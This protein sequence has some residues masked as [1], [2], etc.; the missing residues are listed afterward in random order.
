[1]RFLLCAVML[2]AV[3]LSFSSLSLAA[4]SLDFLD[5]WAAKQSVSLSSLN[6]A[7]P[8]PLSDFIYGELT[9]LAGNE[10]IAPS[11]GLLS[12]K[13]DLA[14]TLLECISTE[15][16]Y[17]AAKEDAALQDRIVSA[18]GEL[19]IPITA[20][21]GMKFREQTTESAIEGLCWIDSLFRYYPLSSTTE[22]VSLQWEKAIRPWNMDITSFGYERF[23]A[24]AK[25]ICVASAYDRYFKNHSIPT[26][27]RGFEWPSSIPQESPISE[28]AGF[29]QRGPY[30]SDFLS[31]II[32]SAHAI[33]YEKLRGDPESLRLFAL[34]EDYFRPWLVTQLTY[35]LERASPTSKVI[36]LDI[37]TSTLSLYPPTQSANS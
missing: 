36:M 25:S 26:T 12:T 16:V 34:L 8:Q 5:T 35:M 24:D 18:I 29:L 10:F 33:D 21:I 11:A 27:Y 19:N 3:V 13:I 7:A 15:S 4:D 32:P 37:I 23:M 22:A 6:D 9:V 20:A 2:S 1:V 14:T 31:C 28:M 17:K 30:A